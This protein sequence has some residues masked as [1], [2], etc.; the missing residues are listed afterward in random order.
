MLEKRILSA[1]PCRHRELRVLPFENRT[2]DKP[3][4]I[5]PTVSKRD[6]DTLIQDRRS[7][8]DLAD[9]DKAYKARRKICTNR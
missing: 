2:E 6:S 9:I 1:D 8:G 3:A 5:L 7:E 4:L